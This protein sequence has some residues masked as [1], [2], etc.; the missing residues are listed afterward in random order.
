MFFSFFLIAFFYVLGHWN[1]LAMKH[2]IKHV[3]FFGPPSTY[4]FYLGGRMPKG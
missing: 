2:K 1:P 4:W 3:A